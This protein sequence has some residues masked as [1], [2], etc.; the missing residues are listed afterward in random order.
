[1]ISNCFNC[2]KGIEAGKPAEHFI[3][4]VY[5]SSITLTTI[6]YGDITPNAHVTKLLAA[7][8]GIIGQFYFVVLVGILISK[9]NQRVKERS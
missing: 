8:F 4:L 5:F 1:L 3:D 6:G 2:F 9:F 7:F